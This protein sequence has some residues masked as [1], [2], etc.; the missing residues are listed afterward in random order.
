M[1]IAVIF[2][3]LS[4]KHDNWHVNSLHCLSCIV[5]T[6]RRNASVLILSGKWRSITL[7]IIER[8]HHHIKPS[9]PLADDISS[10]LFI[11]YPCINSN[12]LTSHVYYKHTILTYQAII[13]SGFVANK[14]YFP[15]VYISLI[16]K[17][18]R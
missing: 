18:V 14:I 5:I 1:H 2:S 3:R 16:A 9:P 6:T 11:A 10:N 17:L 15:L 8:C 7:R 12:L 4:G 13:R